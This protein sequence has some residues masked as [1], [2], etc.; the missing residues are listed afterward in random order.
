LSLRANLGLSRQTR[1]LLHRSSE[2]SFIENVSDRS[3][4]IASLTFTSLPAFCVKQSGHF[5][6]S[7]PNQLPVR[8][9]CLSRPETLATREYSEHCDALFYRHSVCMRSFRVSHGVALAKSLQRC[10]NDACMYKLNT[11]GRRC[12]DTLGFSLDRPITDQRSFEISDYPILL[13]C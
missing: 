12:T 1:A 4:A 2:S 9:P 13:F 8:L 11:N 3:C 10:D 5:R 7:S 6:M